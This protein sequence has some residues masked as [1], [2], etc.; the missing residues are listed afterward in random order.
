MANTDA[1]SY[2]FNCGLA[3]CYLDGV[4]NTPKTMDW[5]N[6]LPCIRSVIQPWCAKA[7]IRRQAEAIILGM[8]VCSYHLCN[9]AKQ[10]VQLLH[11]IVCTCMNQQLRPNIGPH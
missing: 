6:N 11:S 10:D 3:F 9:K 8:Y 7:V 4:E 1:L 5:Q 2:P